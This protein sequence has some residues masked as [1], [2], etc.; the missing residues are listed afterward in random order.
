[1]KIGIAAKLSKLE[2]DMHRLGLS[3]EDV[4]ESYK[5]QKKDVKK[6]LDSHERQKRC[7][8]SITAKTSNAEVVDMITRIVITSFF[9]GNFQCLYW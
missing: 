4:I 9:T 6:I 1:M 8:D 3:R 5:K 2:W 7:I